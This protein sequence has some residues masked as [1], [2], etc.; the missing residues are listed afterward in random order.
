MRR[1]RFGIIGCGLMGREFASAIGRWCHLLELDV[2][3]ELVAVCDTNP[4]LFEWYQTHFPSIELAT[5]SYTD[6]LSDERVE[7]IYCAVPHH[8]HAELYSAIIRAG[9]HLLGEKPFGIDAAANAEIL[10]VIAAHPDVLVRCSSEFPYFPAAQRIIQAVL[11]GP[12]RMGRILEVQAGLHH[13]SD[14]DPHKPLNWKRMIKF[15]GE[16]GCLGDLG[17]HALHIP[18]RLGWRPQDV[19]AVCSNIISE[20]PDGRGGTACC[21]TWDNATLTC[22]TTAPG[23]SDT[24]PMTITTKRISP[25]D[26]NT[27]FLNV[28]GTKCSLEFS[29]RRPKTLRSLTYSEG[30]TQAWTEEDLGYDSVFKAITGGIFEFGFSDAI[31]Q[32]WG[33]FCMELAHGKDS[34]V[35]GCVTPEE[36]ALQHRLLTAALESQ[37]SNSVIRLDGGG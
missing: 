22:N 7:A 20:R 5:E 17:M 15:N 6:L 27:W 18:F 21:E 19:R 24:F 13:C 14:L 25:G 26:T 8:L 3:P 12:E 34:V 33:A 37:S 35:F 29:S 16:Y 1:I 4:S 30:G 36:T 9:K 28:Y 31:L 2:K 23:T 32:M 10:K 11:D